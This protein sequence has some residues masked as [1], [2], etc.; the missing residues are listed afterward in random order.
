MNVCVLGSVRVCVCMCKYKK[1]IDESRGGIHCKIKQQAE[2]NNNY[3]CQ[4]KKHEEGTEMGQTVNWRTSEIQID[5][6]TTQYSNENVRKWLLAS[7]LRTYLC[8]CVC[9]YVGAFVT[10]RVCV[11]V[12]V[13][14]NA[15]GM[16]SMYHVSH[17]ICT[18]MSVSVFVCVCA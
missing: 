18:Y 10:R 12:C 9:V 2:R 15:R 5:L 3:N 8:G 6:C 7:L 11:C 4:G 13:R 17:S 1:G 16:L 14:V